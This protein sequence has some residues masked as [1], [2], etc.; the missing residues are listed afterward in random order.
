MATLRIWLLRPGKQ[1]WLPLNHMRGPIPFSNRAPQE[2]AGL[3][4][5]LPQQFTPEIFFFQKATLF[6]VAS[7]VRLVTVNL[8]TIGR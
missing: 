1:I 8:P 3:A 4:I 7:R 2:R 5:R 6:S